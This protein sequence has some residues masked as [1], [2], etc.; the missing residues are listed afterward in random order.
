MTVWRG[1][2]SLPP[3]GLVHGVDCSWGGW[4]HSTS[5]DAALD[6][7]TPDG[8]ATGVAMGTVA[9]PVHSRVTVTALGLSTQQRQWL[10]KALQPWQQGLANRLILTLNATESLMSGPEIQIN[11]VDQVLPRE[12]ISGWCQR[13]I[14]PQG[15]WIVGAAITLVQPV[16]DRPVGGLAEAGK[17]QRQP[18][19]MRAARWQRTVLHEL[20]HSLGLEH[21]QSKADAMYYHDC[22]TLWQAHQ[23]GLGDKAQL[24]QRYGSL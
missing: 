24:Q 11:L 23:L 19:W 1:A 8:P 14:C 13:Q 17:G 20:G 4:T 7:G 5:V 6:K 12:A 2:S 22:P 3:S 16:L 10:A 9:W 15:R 21:S 18:D